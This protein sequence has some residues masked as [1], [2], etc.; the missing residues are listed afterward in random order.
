MRRLIGTTL[1]GLFAF[2]VTVYGQ[3]SKA[4]NPLVGAWKVTEIADPNQSPITNPQPSLY[5]FAERH[6][7]AVR[8]NGTKP[9]PDYP[10][11]D[12]AT[13]ADKVAVFNA[14]Y[15]NGGTYTVNGNVL[16]TGPF[17]A[18]SAFAMAPGRTTQYEFTMNGNV[19]T[20]AQKPQ[21]TVLKLVRL[22]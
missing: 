7:S 21:G 5:L 22:E 14:L 2:T 6:Y 3:T 18:K 12:K 20:L 11:N 9:L 17:V 15:L 16:T 13:D 19:L 1:L 8:I 4:H 10:S